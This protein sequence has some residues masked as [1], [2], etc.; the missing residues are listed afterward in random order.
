MRSEWTAL[1]PEANEHIR[2]MAERHRRMGEQ[3][4]KAIDGYLRE[5][6]KSGK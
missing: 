3:W 2:H 1:K 4:E 5:Q 6:G